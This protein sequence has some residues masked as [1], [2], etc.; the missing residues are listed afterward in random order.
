MDEKEYRKR[1]PKADTSKYPVAIV[2]TNVRE[3]K[4]YAKALRIEDFK[5]VTNLQMTEGLRTR[6]VIITPGYVNHI[7]NWIFSSM[8]LVDVVSS[9]AYRSDN[10]MG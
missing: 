4:K 2:A 1:F 10:P 7:Q 6:A 9:Q 8:N 5:I 3:G